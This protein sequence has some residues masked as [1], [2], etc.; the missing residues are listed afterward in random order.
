MTS[1]SERW[2]R[3]PIVWLGTAIFCASLAGCIGVIVL[4]SRYEDEPLPVAGERVFKVPALSQ[5]KQ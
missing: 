3:Q 5:E 2:Y 4:A 1:A